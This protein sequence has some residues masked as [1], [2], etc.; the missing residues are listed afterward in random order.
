[1]WCICWFSRIYK[2]VVSYFVFIITQKINQNKMV[3]V[4]V[5][6]SVCVSERE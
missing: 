5:S 6:E 4:S 3:C 2:S 1:M